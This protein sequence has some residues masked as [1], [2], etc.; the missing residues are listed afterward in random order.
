MSG[1][2]QWLLRRRTTAQQQAWIFPNRERH[3]RY[4]TCSSPSSLNCSQLAR[5]LV[6]DKYAWNHCALADDKVEVGGCTPLFLHASGVAGANGQ[7]GSWRRQ[8][9]K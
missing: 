4:K 6:L 8:C 9:T 3:I 2:L 5:T 1:K 7:L